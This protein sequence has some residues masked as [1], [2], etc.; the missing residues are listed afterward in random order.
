VLNSK[1]YNLF[2]TTADCTLSGDMTG[3]FSNTLVSLGA[4][5]DNGGPTLT[6]ALLPDS[7]AIDAGDP[8]GCTD[9]QGNPLATDQRGYGRPVDG[10]SDG[11]ARCDI[12]AYEYGATLPPNFLVFLPGIWR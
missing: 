11:V 5:H 10:D 1:G 7:P 12:G 6:H 8:A 9:A 3:V 4:L 2:G